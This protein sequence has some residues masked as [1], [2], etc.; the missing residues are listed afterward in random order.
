MGKTLNKIEVSAASG[1]IKD[2]MSIKRVLG[3]KLDIPG[4]AQWRFIKKLDIS[5]CW[6]CSNWVYSLVFWSEQI[7]TRNAENN[8][9][10]EKAEKKKL[11]SNIRSFDP[12]YKGNPDVPMLFSNATNWVGKPMIP[13]ADFIDKVGVARNFHR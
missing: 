2:D 7:G 5:D 11:V 1:S 6:N 9:N 3:H 4:A 8:L 13:L 10:I 12:N